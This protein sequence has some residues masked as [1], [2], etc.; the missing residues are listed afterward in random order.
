MHRLLSPRLTAWVA[1][2]LGVLGLAPLVRMVAMF[3]ALPS[4]PMDKVAAASLAVFSLA[5]VVCLATGAWRILRRDDAGAGLRWVMGG[6]VL[7]FISA[8]TPAAS[9]GLVLA[10]LAWWQSSRL[11]RPAAQVPATAAAPFIDTPVMRRLFWVTLAMA[12]VV[13]AAVGAYVKTMLDR[14]GKPTLSW[15]RGAEYSMILILPFA[16]GFAALAFGA[17]YLLRRRLATSPEW[18]AQFGVPC[19]I[20][21]LAGA[22]AGGVYGVWPMMMDVEASLIAVLMPW[23]F[24]Q[25]QAAG[26]AV[27]AAAVYL[28]LRLLGRGRGPR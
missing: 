24:A 28:A 25:W 18:V 20:G 11:P 5:S 14:A 23:W 27:G 26:A 13:L 6:S 15:L 17:R 21:A 12:V 1:I 22:V 3:A 8:I 9:L 4:E 7:T 2:G 16:A 19:W 10:G